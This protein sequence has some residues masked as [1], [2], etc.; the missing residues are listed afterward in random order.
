MANKH[1]PMQVMKEHDDN[2]QLGNI[3]QLNDASIGDKHLLYQQSL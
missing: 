1:K 2:Q 3:V